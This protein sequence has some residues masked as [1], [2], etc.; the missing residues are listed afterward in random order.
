MEEI[1][2]LY[3]RASTNGFLRGKR[4]YFKNDQPYMDIILIL[5]KGPIREIKSVG[6]EGKPIRGYHGVELDY[7]LGE[8]GEAPLAHFED[9]DFSGLALVMIRNISVNDLGTTDP[10]FEVKILGKRIRSMG[11][12]TKKQ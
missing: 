11:S 5:S 12:K 10:V 2:V 1:P 7:R 6:M 4:T 8:K 3:G 9:I